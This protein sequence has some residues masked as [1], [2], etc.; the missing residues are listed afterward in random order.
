[1]L[2]MKLSESVL[3]KEQSIKLSSERETALTLFTNTKYAYE[4]LYADLPLWERTA[5]TTAYAFDHQVIEVDDDDVVIG[6]YNPVSYTHLDVYKRQ[7]YK[8]K[9]LYF[10]QP[11][12]Q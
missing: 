6:R 7:G 10:Q 9:T 1:M 4:I 12:Y 5:R 11:F 8:D 2:N 3:K